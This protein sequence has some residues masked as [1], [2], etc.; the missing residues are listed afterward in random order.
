MLETKKLSDDHHPLVLS[1]AAQ[2]TAS[3]ADPMQKLAA[4]FSFVRDEIRFGFPQ[5]WDA[6]RASETIGFRLGYC[7]TKATLFHA[8]CKTAGIPSR[9][10]TGLID[11]QIMRGIL[12]AFAFPFLPESGGHTWIEV[13]IEGAWQP[14]DSYINDQPFYEQAVRR[15]HAS[16]K[17]TGFSVCE[18]QGPSSSALNF[19]EQGFVHM[20][21]V[22]ADHGTWEDFSAYMASDLYLAMNKI[23]QASFPLIAYFGNRNVAKIRQA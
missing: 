11:I 16:G 10:H 3:L 9:L 12:P 21:A 8:L 13:Q 2:L 14:I 18:A 6:V 15:L 4:I 22:V 1:T 20:G 5:K 17:S 7:N 23:Q 19:G